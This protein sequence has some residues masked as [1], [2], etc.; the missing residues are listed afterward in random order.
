MKKVLLGSLVL[1]LLLCLVAGCGGNGDDRSGLPGQDTNGTPGDNGG[2][3]T[4]APAPGGVTVPRE[5]E[6]L[7]NHFKGAGLQIGAYEPKNFEIIG[8]SAGFGVEVE[9]HVIELY[10]YDPASTDQAVLDGLP[11]KHNPGATAAIV[12][13]GNYEMFVALHPEQQTIIDVF[14]SF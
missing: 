7:I 8:A 4:D 6:Q 10:Y 14:L 5:L 12:I 9:G 13:N 11:G 1:V 3:G 2:G